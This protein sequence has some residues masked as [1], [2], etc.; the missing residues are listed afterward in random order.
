MSTYTFEQTEEYMPDNGDY[1]CEII[2]AKEIM[3]ARDD[4]ASYFKVSFRRADNRRVF[5]KNF[6]VNAEDPLGRIQR[7]IFEVLLDR[8]D[9]TQPKGHVQ[10]AEKLL[11]SMIQ[12][13]LIVRVGNFP[14]STK[15][16][17]IGF[18]K[19]DASKSEERIF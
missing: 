13:Y 15:R 1:L 3:P 19:C 17:V 9:L 10:N 5:V 2:T 4:Y 14:H 7:S 11:Q 18:L 6:Y 16:G 8:I 12:R